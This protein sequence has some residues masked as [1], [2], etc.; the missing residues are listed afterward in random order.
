MSPSTATFTKK[1][2]LKKS[3]LNVSMGITLIMM[4][5]KFVRLL[6]VLNAPALLNAPSAPLVSSRFN[7]MA[8][9]NAMTVM[10]P[11]LT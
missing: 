10:L 3:N 5:V 9:A 4:S 2:Q 11:S 8:L 1:I 7:P 6:A